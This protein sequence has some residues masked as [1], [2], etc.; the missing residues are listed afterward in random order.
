MI[1]TRRDNTI[2]LLGNDTQ[3]VGVFGNFSALTD[4]CRNERIHMN[5]SEPLPDIPGGWSTREIDLGIRRVRLTLPESPDAF[6]DDP[7]VQV[8][9]QESDYMPYWSCLW[10]A[11]IQMGRL[12]ASEPWTAGER[13]LEI[14]AGVGLAGIAGMIAGLDVTFSDYDRT[15]IQTARR[16]AFQNGLGPVPNRA[17]DVLLDWRD[18]AAVQLEPFPVILGCDVLYEPATLEPVLNLLDALLTRDG[19]CWIGDP[20]RQY[21]PEFCDRLADRGYGIELRDETGRVVTTHEL[22]SF[23]LLVLHPC[24]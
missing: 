22:S 16:N 20:G 12:I 2:V 17:M 23:R 9:N 6:L 5:S 11:A 18:T 3:I 7:D 10:P 24:R 4:H 1:G 8:A 15:A 13:S 21:L 14:G 19:V